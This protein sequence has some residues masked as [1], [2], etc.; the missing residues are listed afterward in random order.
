MNI[1]NNTLNHFL[2]ILII[3][4]FCIIQFIYFTNTKDN[5]ETFQI[6]EIKELEKSYLI[7]GNLIDKC[8]FIEK[9]NTINKL[10]N[11]AI[12]IEYNNLNIKSYIIK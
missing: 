1:N 4:L 2:L 5:L 12:K 11:K 10:E 7:C 8:F 6:K 9:D 3:I